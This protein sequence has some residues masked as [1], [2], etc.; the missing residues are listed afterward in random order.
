MW[1]GTSPVPSGR[2]GT[3]AVSD[4]VI[5]D[6]TGAEVAQLGCGILVQRPGIVD[7]VGIAVGASGQQVID[8]HAAAEQR[9]RCIGA[10]E[11]TRCWF[12]EDDAAGE[13]IASYWVAGALPA[14]LLDGRPAL[15][16]FA[17]RTITSFLMTIYC[18]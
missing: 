16:F 4:G 17:P 7:H 3:C 10:G 1:D 18:H 14:M 6:R 9:I 11:R 2:Y 8:R 5:R 13:P 12:G 15:E